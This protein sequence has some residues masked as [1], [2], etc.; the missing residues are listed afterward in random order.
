MRDGASCFRHKLLSP[1]CHSTMAK[2]RT[3]L[4]SNLYLKKI[5]RK[6]SINVCPHLHHPH[7][8]I[9]QESSHSSF[10]V[11]ENR[12]EGSDQQNGSE[13]RIHLE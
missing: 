7:R 9:F 2:I 12:I 5:P 8:K 11:Q 1:S 4:E 13:V 3:E 10:E 6:C